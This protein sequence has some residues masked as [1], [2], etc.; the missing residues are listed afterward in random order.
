MAKIVDF[1]EIDKQGFSDLLQYAGLIEDGIILNK[2]GSFMAGFAIKGPDVRNA[3][4]ADR[5]Y[6]A[7]QINRTL[8]RFGNGYMIHVDAVRQRSD[9]Y[10]ERARSYFKDDVT[11]LIDEERRTAFEKHS[12][13]FETETFVV[14]TYTPP[15][16]DDNRFAGYF[17]EKQDNPDDMSLAEKSLADFRRAVDNFYKQLSNT[18]KV[19][20]LQTYIYESETGDKIKRCRFLE[21][22][23]FCITGNSNPVNLPNTPFYLDYLLGGQYISGLQPRINNMAIGCVSVT[24]FPLETYPG[25][26]TH[27]DNLPLQYR[28][29]T[30]FIFMSEHTAIKEM[31]RTRKKWNGQ[32]LSL[33]EQIT[34]IKGRSPNQDA[35]NMTA[36]VQAAMLEVNE[37]L[38]SCGYYTSQIVVYHEDVKYLD[39]VLKY[40]KQQMD[41]FGF[42]AKIE[43]LNANDCY[44]GS[45]PGNNF[46]NIRRPIINTLNLSHLLPINSVWAG[47]NEAPC[48]FY[49]SES[50]PLM[51]V[52]SGGMTPFRVNLH[53]GDVGHTL[54]FGPTG[55]GKSTFLNLLTAQFRRYQNAQVFVFD[56]GGSSKVLTKS[57][58]GQ[59]YDVGGE[60][61]DV[62]FSP[63]SMIENDEDQKWAEQWISDLIEIQGVNV[64]PKHRKLIHEAMS[65]LVE[66]ESISSMT[67]FISTLQDAELKEALGY[68]SV[69]GS[70]A[71]LLDSEEDGLGISDFISFEME[72][73]MNMGEKALVPVL[74]YLFRRLEKM[75]TGKPTLLV[76]D[77]AWV[78]LGHPVFREKIREW[79]KVL[80]KKNCAVVLATQSLSD[81]AKSGITDVLYESC[82]TKILLPNPEAQTE[83]SRDF[84]RQMGLN[85]KQISIVATS[86]MKRDYYMITSEGKRLFDMELGPK[87][88][89]F[90]GISNP[91]HMKAFDRIYDPN[92]KSWI[93]KWLT[94]RGVD[95][96]VS[97]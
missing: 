42:S 8:A 97:A 10:P 28:F 22:L 50:P 38:V 45:L 80:R 68:Y 84:Y 13:H 37:G 48:P 24:G 12:S 78:M 65:T 70:L 60:G 55:A 25:I 26:L 66:T 83:F 32:I 51:I 53:V 43:G 47:H 92:D 33:M 87:A 56:K 49:P 6:T 52:G 40:I 29:S 15:K 59:Y 96:A 77:E 79:L 71:Y 5:N 63:L 17:F 39:E 64:T 81:A 88:L 75:M 27:L 72:T 69:D 35:A 20:R 41:K 58:G 91:E 73:L 19:E 76:L 34:G 62:L 2:D 86:V 46:A 57:V 30:R 11:K 21:H 61:G 85:S 36:D 82:P 90:V 44:F 89:A 93:E 4:D 74:L 94:N 14:L 16:L 3:T 18:L 31:D 95:N 9:R 54:V 67:N 23:R 1:L 7:T